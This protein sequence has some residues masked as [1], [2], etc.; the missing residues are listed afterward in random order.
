MAGQT[1]LHLV[2]KRKRDARV[3]TIYEGTN[4]I[5]R[6]FILKDLAGEVAPRWAN[7][8]GPLSSNLGREAV[9]LEA[10]KLKFRQ[11]L[12]SALE[13]FG[14]ELWQNPSLQANC[15]LLSE[16][17]A[18]LKGAD[19]TLARLAWLDLTLKFE[20]RGWKIEDG[21]SRIEDRDPRSSMLD[22]QLLVIG[23]RALTRCY[24]EITHR[25]KRFDEE[26]MHLRRGYYAPEIRAA[27]LLFRE[28]PTGIPS[29][30]EE[31]DGSS[32]LRCGFVSAGETPEPARASEFDTEARS[33]VL[34]ILVV[35]QPTAEE[36]PHPHVV[37]GRLF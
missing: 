21:R 27:S 19:S 7:P 9:E 16:A 18:W 23:R 11:R 34:S 3:L 37:N 31:C 29:A 32:G 33:R 5:Q 10:L 20:D 2:E 1:E 6:F 15:F 8:I 25:L 35:V 24:D 17:A 36:I 13:L 28:E 12:N 26:L 4:E 30:S 22:P 14:Q